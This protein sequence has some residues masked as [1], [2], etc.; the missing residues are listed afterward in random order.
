MTLIDLRFPIGRARGLFGRA[1]TFLY[2][3]VKG[4]SVRVKA[5]S[6]MGKR[7]TPSCGAIVCP[8]CALAET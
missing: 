7:Y 8:Q 6:R 2:Y 3:C 1:P 4:H 5:N